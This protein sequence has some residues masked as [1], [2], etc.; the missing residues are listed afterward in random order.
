MC[1]PVAS[2]YL[3]STSPASDPSAY[4]T[5]VSSLLQMY[6]DEIEFEGDV[7]PAR[8]RRRGAR[9]IADHNGSSGRMPLIVNT[10][11]WVKGLGADL[12]VKLK[13]DVRPTHIYSIGRT[14][15]DHTASVSS[16]THVQVVQLPAAPSSPLE[17][18]WSTADLRTLALIAYF[19]SS[20]PSSTPRSYSN[21][22]PSAWDFSTPL[23]SRSPYTIDWT[24]SAGQ[25]RAV[26]L[27]DGNDV[28]YEQIL[29][30]LN[31]SLVAISLPSSA[32]DFEQSL[33]PTAFPYSSAFS[34]AL[35]SPATGS[36]S[37]TQSFGL[38]LVRSIDPTA[39][40]LHILTPVPLSRIALETHDGL[41]L[42]HK[43]SD[44][45][46]VELPLPLML[47]H[48]ATEA[49]AAKGVCGTEWKD[50][51]YLSVG[52]DGG[53]GGSGRRRVRRNLMRR[54]QA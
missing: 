17:S 52:G 8:S 12:L 4:S 20:F 36:L 41:V 14:E 45:G 37:L 30:V 46:G 31:G 38:G 1:V 21:R 18:K 24:A 48:T 49:E 22:F 54:A 39:H 35:S 53:Q 26:Q 51:P 6:R 28:P 42:L 29:H 47:D 2:H 5:A 33:S 16:H 34:S 19:H 23:V 7:V 43:S 10:Q 50:V 13:A 27:L 15:E 32:P 44:G 3:G 25:L 40:A 9:E 11:G